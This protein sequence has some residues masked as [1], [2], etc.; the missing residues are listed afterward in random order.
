MKEKCAYFAFGFT[1]KDGRAST[2]DSDVECITYQLAGSMKGRNPY[3]E[4]GFQEWGLTFFL[5]VRFAK[6]SPRF[7]EYAQ[8]SYDAEDFVDVDR[9][10]QPL[11]DAALEEAVEKDTAIEEFV[12][13]EE[14]FHEL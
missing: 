14:L 13:E 7:E 8:Q 2:K 3:A 1:T 4:P 5:S 10:G 11:E 6:Y 12:E 9:F